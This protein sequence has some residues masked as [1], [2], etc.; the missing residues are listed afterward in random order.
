MRVTLSDIQAARR[1]IAGHVLHTP[2]R[3]GRAME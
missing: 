3:D 2:M 1:T